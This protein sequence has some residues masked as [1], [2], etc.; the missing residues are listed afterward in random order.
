MSRATTAGVLAL[1]S[2]LSCG[3]SSSPQSPSS[4]SPSET[5]V[6]QDEFAG[7]GVPDASRWGY[8][9][10]LIRN[11]ERQYTSLRTVGYGPEEIDTVLLTHLHGDHAGGLVIAGRMTFAN[12]SI[13]L[14]R[15][16]RVPYAN[17]LQKPGRRTIDRQRPADCV[18]WSRTFQQK[19]STPSTATS[20]SL[21]AFQR[22]T[23]TGARRVIPC[24]PQKARVRRSCSGA[25]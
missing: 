17:K 6:W 1:W 9:V 14:D 11:N 25:T 3:G 15:T 4:P 23:P 22:S 7:Q 16:K 8:E 5:L 21:P 13:Y 18:G 2:L 24:T 10:G 19:G 20:N 12:A